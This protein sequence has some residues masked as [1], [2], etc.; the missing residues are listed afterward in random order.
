MLNANFALPDETAE[1]V[2]GA[3]RSDLKVGLRQEEM[4]GR[5]AKRMT[6]EDAMKGCMGQSVELL[7]VDGRGVE[8]SIEMSRLR[9]W[10]LL[11]GIRLVCS[12]PS[13][14]QCFLG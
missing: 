1:A 10:Q 2:K 7:T 14:R 3:L 13:G 12:Q 5:A 4:G 6:V 8:M 11:N 9:P